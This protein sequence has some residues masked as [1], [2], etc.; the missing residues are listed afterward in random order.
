[1]NIVLYSNKFHENWLPFFKQLI[2]ILLEMEFKVQAGK[3]LHQSSAKQIIEEHQIP[4]IAEK[5]I[6]L[7]NP[8]VMLV[9]GGD[10]T[11]LSSIQYIKKTHIP[12]M[13]INTGRLGFLASVSKEE[14]RDALQLLK[15]NKFILDKRTL[16]QVKSN[17]D[18]FT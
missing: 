15:Q 10:G 4:V 14:M 6:P 18:L 3:K 13:G 9:I 7:Y 5:D 1:M 11:L 2:G 17:P 16:L 12:L 8:D